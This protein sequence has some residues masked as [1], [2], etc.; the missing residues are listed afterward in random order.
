M[1]KYDVYLMPDA[2]KDLETIYS[3]IAE[4]SGFPERAWGYVEKL[5]QKCHELETAPLRGQ[6][7]DDLLP[8]LRVAPI[9]KKAV[10]AF[11]VDEKNR[12]F[13]SSISSMGAGITK[14]SCRNPPK[15]TPN[16]PRL[17][18]RIMSVFSK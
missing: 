16:K 14:P 10:A 18:R 11:L 8:N 13:L 6:Q 7:R 3:Y 17:L 9:D 2:I 4:K 1:G 12:P 5:R 15:T